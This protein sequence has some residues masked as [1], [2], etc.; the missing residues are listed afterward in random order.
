M[1]F[2][3]LDC[4]SDNSEYISLFLFFPISLGISYTKFYIYK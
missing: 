4:I 3:K 2:K 1:L